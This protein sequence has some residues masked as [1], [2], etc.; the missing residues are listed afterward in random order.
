[1]L[2]QIQNVSG[3]M[4]G[5]FFCF[6]DLA[7]AR[8]ARLVEQKKLFEFMR[9]CE[10]TVAWMREKE[11]I[12]GSEDYGTDVEHVEVSYSDNIHVC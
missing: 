12:A 7:A 2:N 10:E 3:C 6:Q 8:R 4:S 11:A 9:E 5:L 1:M